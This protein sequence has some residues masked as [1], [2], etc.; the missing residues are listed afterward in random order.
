MAVDAGTFPWP[1][2]PDANVAKLPPTNRK[3]R[4]SPAS[5]RV[6]KGNTAY[7][8]QFQATRRVYPKRGMMS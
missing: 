5:Q 6:F 1:S 3:L 4:E 2:G 8:F 7:P